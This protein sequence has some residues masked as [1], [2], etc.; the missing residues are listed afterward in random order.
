MSL[1]HFPRKGLY[2]Y[3]STETILMKAL[4]QLGM[5]GEMATRVDLRSGDIL[6][7]NAAGVMSRGKFDD[8]SLWNYPVYS[9]CYTYDSFGRNTYAEELKSVA[10]CFGFEPESIDRLLHLGFQ[11]EEIEEFMYAGEI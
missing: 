2:L 10:R 11:P 7:I 5:V 8:R 3:A 1:Y 9:S 4:S 6:K